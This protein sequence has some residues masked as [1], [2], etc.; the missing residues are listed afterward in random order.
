[1]RVVI[2]YFS[3]WV[4]GIIIFTSAYVIYLRENDIPV[5]YESEIPQ[6]VRMP[7]YIFAGCFLVF[8]FLFKIFT[9]YLED[10]K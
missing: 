7:V 4:T 9:T 8:L 6:D 5:A 10:S 2:T 1:M 3:T